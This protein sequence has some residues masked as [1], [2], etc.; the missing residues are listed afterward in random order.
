MRRKSVVWVAKV[1]V[2]FSGL[3]GQITFSMPEGDNSDQEI[4]VFNHDVL[5]LE[6][7]GDVVEVDWPSST[8]LLWR[9]VNSSKNTLDLQLETLVEIPNIG[10]L[11]FEGDNSRTSLVKLPNGS[12][13]LKSLVPRRVQSY[14]F[15]HRDSD[16]A[17]SRKAGLTIEIKRA[18][19][20]VVIHSSCTSKQ[21]TLDLSTK[22]DAPP[23]YI[24]LECT[25]KFPRILLPDNF[26]GSR[27]EG[28]SFEIYRTLEK[29]TLVGK[30]AFAKELPAPEVGERAE[31]E[32]APPPL[33]RQ[34]LYNVGTGIKFGFLNGWKGKSRL[35]D[36]PMLLEGRWKRDGR[37]FLIA[38]ISIPLLEHRGDTSI[39][40]NGMWPG[41]VGIGLDALSNDLKTGFE[42][43][44]A[45]L[46][47][48]VAWI[49]FLDNEPSLHGGPFFGFHWNL[50]AWKE[51]YSFLL[52]RPFI[53]FGSPFGGG[54]DFKLRSPLILHNFFLS[55]SLE[56]IFLN[57][58]RSII[59]VGGAFHFNF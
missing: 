28:S 11:Q 43:L 25:G 19:P 41:S 50:P 42:Q 20:V 29:K 38:D 48:Q 44:D 55:L 56:S 27:E 2:V 16:D 5:W 9:K 40:N 34:S 53:W 47:A 18:E 39:F 30:I 13:N 54:V 15:Y 36:L 17:S 6:E 46:G 3:A 51:N 32:K 37:H 8:R 45:T 26:E 59:E 24:G 33:I 23:L 58:D 14:T 35:T 57:Q 31:I 7:S 21:Y 10:I 4:Q 52:L 49:N 1:F 22:E 12:M